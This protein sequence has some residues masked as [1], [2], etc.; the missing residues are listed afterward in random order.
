MFTKRS[1]SGGDQIP[2]N[3][4]VESA[5]KAVPSRAEPASRRHVVWESGVEPAQTGSE[6][7]T[8]G[9]GEEHGNPAT[10]TGE[11]IPLR[12]ADFGNEPLAP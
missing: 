4:L 8:V 10:Q 12:A 3:E 7:T 1:S 5:L 2:L 11:L 6:H 9:L